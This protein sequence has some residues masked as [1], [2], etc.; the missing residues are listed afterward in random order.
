MKNHSQSRSKLS[1]LPVGWTSV[2]PPKSQIGFGTQSQSQQAESLLTHADEGHVM[3]IAPTGAG[4]GVSAVIPALLSHPG[5]VFVIDLKGENYKVAARRRRELGHTVVGLDPFNYLLKDP[6]TFNA[7]DLMWLPGSAP[8]CDSE[9]IAELLCGG[10]TSFSKDVFWEISG[11]G[12][13]TGL[14]GLAGED[15]D[16]AQRNICKVLDYLYADDVDYSIALQLDKHQFQNKLARQELV[17]YLQHEQDKCRPSVKSTAQTMTKSLGSECVRASLSRT[18]FDLKGWLRG[19]P[20]DIF[21]IFPPDKLESH[22]NLLRLIL[23]ALTVVLL[24]RQEIPEH[25]T[26]LLLDECAQLGN[27]GMLRTALTLLRGY[28]TQVWSFWQDLSQLKHLYPSDW[29]TILNNSSV[30]QAFGFTNAWMAKCSADVMGM[31][32]DELLEM[33]RDEQVLLRP[34]RRAEKTR[35][36]NYLTDAIFKGQFDPNPRYAKTGP[37]TM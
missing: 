28:G 5:P 34:G 26:L 21:L 30:V 11:R 32:A 31:P 20:I 25:R 24:R 35:R 27:L 1:G 29:E 22:R 10:Q 37:R 33:G 14:I 15:A 9:L 23:G 16:P 18:S 19:D 13:N 7:L 8:D 6:D 36:V 4:K 2:Q 3:T 17:A 12:M